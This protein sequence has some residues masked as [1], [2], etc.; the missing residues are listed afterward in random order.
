MKHTR[1]G[2]VCKIRVQIPAHRQAPVEGKI[3]IFAIQTGCKISN[4]CNIYLQVTV[5]K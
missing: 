4:S 5:Q 3:C 1:A 2:I